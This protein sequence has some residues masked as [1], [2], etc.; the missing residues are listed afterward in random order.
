M[1]SKTFRLGDVLSITTGKLLSRDGIGGVYEI[2]N[3]MTGDD[4]FTHALPRA[5]RACRPILLEIFPA[6]VGEDP[7][8]SGMDEMIA[9]LDE[10]ESRLGDSFEIPVLGSGVYEAKHPLTELHEMLDKT[11]DTHA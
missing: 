11:G 2:L 4:L 6:L 7:D 10:A 5:G 3:H 8:V 1:E 9:Y